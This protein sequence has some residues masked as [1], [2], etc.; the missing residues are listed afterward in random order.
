MYPKF[1]F[2]YQLFP[3]G[4]IWSL[5]ILTVSAEKLQAAQSDE[6]WNLDSQLGEPI[7][8][9]TNLDNIQQN[10]PGIIETDSLFS[11]QIDY[12]WNSSS[13]LTER[14][15]DV[16]ILENLDTDIDKN[17][18]AYRLEPTPIL[19]AAPE[20]FNPGLWIPPPSPPPPPPKPPPTESTPGSPGLVLEN[21]QTDFR[22]DSSKFFQ[23]NQIIEPTFQFRL[24]N[25]EKLKLRTGFNTFEQPPKFGTVTNIPFQVGWQGKTGEYTIQLAGGIDW[26]N[27]LPIAFNFNA[28]IDRPIFVN[29]TPTYQLQSALFLSAV[30][31]HGPYKTSAQTLQ[32]QIKSWRTGLNAFWQ[33]EPK[34]SFF[35]LY[36]IGFYNDGN[37]EQQLFSRLEHKFL[38]HFWIAT[39]LFAWSYTRDCQ[40]ISGYFSPQSFLVYNAEIGWTADIFSFLSCRA[41]A[42]LGRQTLNGNT[43]GGISYQ[44]HCT[45]QI[46]PNIDL[47]FGYTFSNVRNLDTG[48]SPYNNRNL[49]G[50]LQIKF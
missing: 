15:T 25:G 31:E 8:L 17:L 18:S 47:D 39:N 41:N 45:T 50:Q 22:D 29:L 10:K 3:V 44:G 24:P 28:Q 6:N 27:R 32:S 43:T 48:N 11:S 20:N 13:Q 30:L 34:T 42:N 16:A 46:L 9:V 26:F 33:I 35:T 49:S 2:G 7:T 36:R 5:I 38:G 40:E 1:F 14:I 21:I 23:H 4:L 37:F 12:K 19:I